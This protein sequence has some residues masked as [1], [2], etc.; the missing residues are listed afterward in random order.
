MTSTNKVFKFARLK[1]LSLEYDFRDFG[2]A[3]TVDD[4][5]QEVTI[6]VWQKLHTF[7]GEPSSFYAW[8][9][10]I[11]FSKVVKAFT[12]LKAEQRNKESL[13]VDKR[14]EDRTYRA[15]NPNMYD[16]GNWSGSLHQD[17]RVVAILKFLQVWSSP[18]E[19]QHEKLKA[20]WSELVPKSFFKIGE[21]LE[22]SLKKIRE[23]LR[24]DVTDLEIW[25]LKADDPKLSSAG[26]GR[27]LTK[28]LT[29]KAVDARLAAMKAMLTHNGYIVRRE[30]QEAEEDLLTKAG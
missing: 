22:T 29:N 25:A 26:I 11:C 28:P 13:V 21:S 6:T 8:V 19:T 12:N 3:E 10:K 9:H 5:A 17:A 30:H 16:Q 20:I 4:W 14:T 23:N 15:D 2:T 18:D 24:L 1:L 7:K 27:R